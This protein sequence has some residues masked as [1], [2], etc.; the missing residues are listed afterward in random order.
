MNTIDGESVLKYS[1]IEKCWLCYHLVEPVNEIK[2]ESQCC[3]KFS[4][5]GAENIL[6]SNDPSE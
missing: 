3:A 1:D 5:L 2:A 6:C 4:I